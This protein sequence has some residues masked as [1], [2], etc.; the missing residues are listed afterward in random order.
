MK[1]RIDLFKSLL[2]HHRA[3]KHEGTLKGCASPVCGVGLDA[4]AL[5]RARDIYAEVAA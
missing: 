3:S 1:L 4:L 5:T 2:V